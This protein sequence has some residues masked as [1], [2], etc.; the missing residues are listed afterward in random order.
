MTPDEV[1]Q[2]LE[3]ADLPK[4][5]QPVF[6]FN[7][8]SDMGLTAE[9]EE[10]VIQ[11]ALTSS[12]VD[13]PNGMKLVPIKVPD[14]ID[15]YKFMDVLAAGYQCYLDMRRLDPAWIANR[16]NG[17]SVAQVGF[18]INTEQYSY[19]M[20]CRGI[21]TENVGKLTP[22]MDAALM[23]LTDIGS[24]KDWG[25]RLKDAGITQAIFTAWMKNP[26]FSQRFTKLSEDLT[27]NHGLA[28]VQLGQRVGQ[29]D[30][31]AI[32]LQLEVS[33]RYSSAQQQTIDVMVMMNRVLES[34]SKHLATH[35]EILQAISQDLR[36]VAEDVTK[37]RVIEV[38]DP[39]A[40][41]ITF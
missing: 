29:G 9:G 17:L 1:R 26:I 12:P 28:L 39:R 7:G 18:I 13:I 36:A 38:S 30:M 15:R 31:N 25:G 27:A 19:A 11:V 23:I 21:D 4:Y 6:D 24:K 5:E 10:D 33:G 2:S 41:G 37:Q 20:A 3:N 14:N 34:L 16:V 35:P 32:K 22:Q 8:W 40:G